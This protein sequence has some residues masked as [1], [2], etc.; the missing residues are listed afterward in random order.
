MT[1]VFEEEDWKR[2]LQNLQHLW[3]IVQDYVGP[4]LPIVFIIKNFVNTGKKRWK[5]WSRSQEALTPARATH[6]TQV[7]LLL[8]AG[9]DLHLLYHPNPLLAHLPGARPSH[10]LWITLR[11]ILVG[12]KRKRSSSGGV[13]HKKVKTRHRQKLPYNRIYRLASIVMTYEYNFF[14][15]IINACIRPSRWFSI[16]AGPFP[17]S[18]IIPGLIFDFL[19]R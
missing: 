2:F 11:T 4:Q 5:R 1:A 13:H 15:E 19:S 12:T 10:L 8:V 6:P 14:N 3:P 18:L 7:Q 17:S 9:M 16:Y